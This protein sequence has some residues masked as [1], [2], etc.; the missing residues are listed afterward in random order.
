MALWR[1][2]IAASGELS[3]YLLDAVRQRRLRGAGEGDVLDEYL[4]VAIDDHIG[5]GQVVAGRTEPR[6]GA[7][8]QQGKW[9]YIPI[10]GQLQCVAQIVEASQGRNH[11][12]TRV[13][14]RSGAARRPGGGD[15]PQRLPISPKCRT[16]VWIMGVRF[17]A[18]ASL[19]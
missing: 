19:C 18:V 11:E 2:A 13:A 12:V 14:H 7:W 17:I 3:A 4:Q 16:K 5:D 10:A 1:L 6:S 9:N 8:A 15:M